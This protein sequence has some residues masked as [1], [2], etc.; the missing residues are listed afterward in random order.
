MQLCR[1]TQVL[2]FPSNVPHLTLYRIRLQPRVRRLY[3]TGFHSLLEHIGFLRLT[4]HVSKS[5]SNIPI[6][7]R[8]WP[9]GPYAHHIKH[10]NGSL[11][12][13]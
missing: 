13:T 3:S 5:S 11:L 9:L 1:A 8:A 4:I 12:L 2:G 6:Q 10:R 7:D